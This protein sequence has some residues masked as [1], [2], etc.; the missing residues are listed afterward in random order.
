MTT[1]PTRPPATSSTMLSTSSFNRRVEFYFIEI[2]K[3]TNY[4]YSNLELAPNHWSS[5][6][7]AAAGDDRSA[8]AEVPGHLGAGIMKISNE[9]SFGILLVP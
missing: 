2:K 1:V 3:I 8:G 7:S 9:L 5:W 4:T 6:R